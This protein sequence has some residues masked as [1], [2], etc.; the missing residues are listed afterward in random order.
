MDEHS[1]ILTDFPETGITRITLNRPGKRNA[2][3]P[4]L[5]EAL[6]TALQSALASRETRVVILQA[7][8]GHFSAGGDIASLDGTDTVLGR[9]R[10]QRG[11]LVVR[12][13][14]R[15]EKPVIAA[16]EGYAMGAGAGLALAC[17]TVVVDSA[18][19]IGFPFLKVGLGP[20]FGVTYTLPRRIGPAAARHAL[21]HAKTF[22]GPEAAMKGL[23]DELAPDG[24]VKDHALTLARALAALPAAAIALTKRQLAATPCDFETAAE[25]EAL[26]QAVCFVGDEFREGLTAFREKRPTRF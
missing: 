18:T 12:E 23:A 6:Y 1:L 25:M 9:E 16:V 21:L 19:R 3:S 14:L 10:I 4:D 7:E 13:I 8:G 24:T 20:D 17:D 5:R 26:G 2:F 22:D 11:H 15:S